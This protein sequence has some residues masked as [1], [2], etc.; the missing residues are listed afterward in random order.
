MRL[1]ALLLSADNG[2]HFLLCIRL[3]RFCTGN[4]ERTVDHDRTKEICLALHFRKP[5]QLRQHQ[6]PSWANA[7]SEDHVRSCAEGC[8]NSVFAVN[9]GH[10]LLCHVLAMVPRNDGCGQCAVSVFRVV[11]CKLCAIWPFCLSSW[12]QKVLEQEQHMTSQILELEIFSHRVV[13]IQIVRIFVDIQK[14]QRFRGHHIMSLSGELLN[15]NCAA[16]A[17]YITMHCW[18]FKVFTELLSNF[19]SIY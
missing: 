19:K 2:F 18:A 12:L 14:H 13:R 17:W 7:A 1:W 15:T 9:R 4:Y 10:S 3:L 16:A 6:L 5:S 11:L 8:F